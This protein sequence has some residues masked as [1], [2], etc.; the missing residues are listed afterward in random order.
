MRDDISVP[1]EAAE[2]VIVVQRPVHYPELLLSA[3]H[4]EN[5]L[6]VMRESYKIDPIIFIVVSVDFPKVTFRIYD[7]TYSPF[8][9][10][11][12]ATEKSSLPAT[13]YLPSWEMST[14]FTSFC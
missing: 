9:R 10:S 2:N 3:A 7:N 12:R 5:A 4:A 1:K 14:E 13:R 11:Y 8:S 6:V